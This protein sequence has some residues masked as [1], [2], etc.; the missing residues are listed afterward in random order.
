M[1][2]IIMYD[3]AATY[4]HYC[5]EGIRNL[6]TFRT[7]NNH[8]LHTVLVRIFI[9][10]FGNH[11]FVIRAPSFLFGLS[12]IILIYYIS[13]LFFNKFTAII[14]ILLYSSFPILIHFESIARGYSPKI[15]FSLMLFISCYE[16]V[17][18]PSKK[19]M[20][21]ISIISS[22]GFLTIFSFILPFL[23]TL[24]WAI[25]QMYNRKI[26][27]SKIIVGFLIPT[28]IYTTIL[29]LFLYIPS[30]ILSMDFFVYL[31]N[32]LATGGKSYGNFPGDIPV[33]IKE[34]FNLFFFNNFFIGTLII[35]ASTYLSVKK[36]EL[37]FL[38]FSHL[39][40]SVALVIIF[41]ALFPARSFIFLLPFILILTSKVI[42]LLFCKF[43]KHIA[44]IIPL[45]QLIFY[46]NIHKNH[47]FDLYHNNNSDLLDVVKHMNEIPTES[48]VY[49]LDETG[50]YMTF[51]FYHRLN[52]LPVIEAISYEQIEENQKNS[53]FIAYNTSS[54]SF[55]RF[56]K[57]FENDT[58]SIYK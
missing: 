38:V 29:S 17:N 18:K 48:K 31:A 27:K 26:L 30:I 33:M 51:K 50:F 55:I 57:I 47:Y 40:A 4:L 6:L 21:I 8:V 37:A 53:Y 19:R 32:A 20:L 35:C 41:K 10:F 9:E 42:D 7:L 28:A 3:E 1:S 5:D 23:G 13:R 14:S 36:N 58:F 15:T 11:P 39:I 2:F 44:L 24:L 56:S 25:I 34:V 16:F 52:S 45:I 46:L 22:L 54:R 49:I 12:N 43:Q